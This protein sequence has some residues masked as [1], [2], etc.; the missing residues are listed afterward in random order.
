MEKS[1][2][3][4]LAFLLLFQILENL[5]SFRFFAGVDVQI[6]HA[7]GAVWLN[8]ETDDGLT[9]TQT[10]APTPSQE[11]PPPPTP[12]PPPS[13]ASPPPQTPRPPPTPSGYSDSNHK[14]AH[15]ALQAWKSAITDD[16][17]KILETWVGPDVCSYTGVFC[18]VPDEGDGLGSP[19][20]PIVAGIDLNNAN[21]QGSLVKEL[22]FFTNMSLF[23][24]NSN[25]FSGAIPE[26]F[27]HFT[28]L[29]EL[30]LSNNHFSGPFP[31]VI[32]CIPNLVYLD[33]RF[34]SFSGPIPDELFN[35]KID[36]IFLNDNQFDG[37]IPQNLGNSA[38][39]VINFANNKLTGSLP[40]S[41]GQMGQ[42]LKE[43]LFLN[44]HITGCIPKEFGLLSEMEVFDVSNNSLVGK[45]PDTF[46]CLK[47]IEVLNLG[48]N[49]LSGVLPY[50]ICHL[51][52]LMNLTVSNNFFSGFNHD[53]SSL[54]SRNVGFD[55]SSNC[56]I[57]S[58]LQKPQPECSNIPGADGICVGSPLTPMLRGD[59]EV[60]VGNLVP[61]SP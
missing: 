48:N 38:A 37:Q 40:T 25:R 33:L 60:S 27:Q 23:H 43:I 49:Q 36:A 16:P 46:S 9:Q 22:S 61:S 24:L 56:I 51:K 26:F 55:F 29:E 50:Q 32:L 3:F 39:S 57:G 35:K 10:Q 47:Q 42:T 15:T 58:L 52:N 2:F 4:L 28:S 53:C 21:L 6:G 17:L 5:A 11:P 54:G 12:L 20:G 8:G 19:H 31:L 41:F 14:G 44:N 7:D 45:L 34:N 30:D 59:F 1:C 13:Q 18:G